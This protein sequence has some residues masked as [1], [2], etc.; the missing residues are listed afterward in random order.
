MSGLEEIP[1]TGAPAIVTA[2]GMGTVFL[3]LT[4]LYVFTRV[5]GSTIPQLLASAEAPEPTETAASATE[6]EAAQP[7]ATGAASPR[8]DEEVTAA[9]T[10][11]LARHRSSRARSLI[12][13]ARRPSSWK[14]AG[15]VQ[16]LRRK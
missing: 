15:R 11:A 10:I 9:I 3:C 16:A 8:E 6:D 2:L 14:M 7:P 13:E 4:L 1:V 5:M 12:R